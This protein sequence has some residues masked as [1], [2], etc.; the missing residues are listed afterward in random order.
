MQVGATSG[1]RKGDLRLAGDKAGGRGELLREGLAGAAGGVQ[2]RK[3]RTKLGPTLSPYTERGATPVGGSYFLLRFFSLVR[4][5]FWLLGLGVHS[6]NDLL[7]LTMY[8]R[9]ICIASR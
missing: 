1:D 8:G 3:A 4:P 6:L 9:P 2:A 7:A 5:A